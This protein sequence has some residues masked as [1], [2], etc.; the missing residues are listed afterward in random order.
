MARYRIPFSVY[1]S[2][3]LVLFFF[4]CGVIKQSRYIPLE[5]Q[6]KILHSHFVPF[7]ESSI[8][9]AEILI[10]QKQLSGI[11]VFKR[12]APELWRIVFINEIGMKFFDLKLARDNFEVV[13]CYQGLKRKKLLSL[14]EQDF[15]LLLIPPEHPVQVHV[16]KEK[17]NVSVF[18]ERPEHRKGWNIYYLSGNNLLLKE[19]ESYGFWEKKISVSFNSYKRNHP[20]SFVI[21]HNDVKLK[22]HFKLLDN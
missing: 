2:V 14:L 6:T 8:F 5:R 15:R 9:K 22:L 17:N 12:T 16:K 1:S 7:P 3:F 10:R 21:N 13:E 4:S 20:D 11:M 19:T 18:L